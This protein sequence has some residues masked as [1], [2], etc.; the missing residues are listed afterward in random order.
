ML[1]F[2]L[3]QLNAQKLDPA[4]DVDIYLA[5]SELQVAA[6]KFYLREGFKFIRKQKYKAWFGLVSLELYIFCCKV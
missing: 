1:K 5:T 6:R 2:V 4:C 3:A